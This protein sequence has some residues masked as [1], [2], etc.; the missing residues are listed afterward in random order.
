MATTSYQRRIATLKRGRRYPTQTPQRN[1]HERNTTNESLRRAKP[2][3][4][5]LDTRLK[6]DTQPVRPIIFYL[7]A[8]ATIR[9]FPRDVRMEL[10]FDLLRLQL[11]ESLRM[12]QFR[13]MPA[14]AP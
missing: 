5:P 14:V 11:G 13:P 6:F 7:Q 3:L 8:R 2:D 1:K 4:V 12:P 9:T 10:G